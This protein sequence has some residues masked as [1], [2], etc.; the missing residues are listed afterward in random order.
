MSEIIVT[1]EMNAKVRAIVILKKTEIIA[2]KEETTTITLNHL[3]PATNSSL[4]S[5]ASRYPT[6]KAKI[7]IP[8]S[9]NI[10]KLEIWVI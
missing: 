6:G 9:N 10:R 2:D 3:L 4:A 8:I 5:H 1:I 7:N